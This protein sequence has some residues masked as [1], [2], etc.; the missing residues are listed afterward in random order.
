MN[1]SKLAV[2]PAR[3][4][5]SP[6]R[7]ISVISLVIFAACAATSCA[8]K[9]MDRAELALGTV[10][11]IRIQA[12][13]SDKA[14]DQAFARIKEI[15]RE[16][17]ANT[18]D[19]VIAAINNAAGLSPVAAPEDLRFVISKALNYAA[20]S[21][22]AFDPTIGPIVKLWN[23]GSDGERVP[24][25]AE[26]R[27]TLKL[28]GW[29][30]VV[31]DNAAGTVFLRRPGMR[32]DLGAIAKGYAADEVERTLLENRVRAAVIDLGGNVK[33]T[34]RKT[35]GSKWRVGIQNPFDERGARLG[36]AALDGGYTVVTSGVYERYF[37]GKDGEHYHHIL[38]TGTGYPVK[39]GLV[40]VTIIC[41][42]SVDADGLSTS[43]FALGLE[44]GSALV[45]SLP[46]VEAVF[47][48]AGKRVY[49]TS[50]AP[51]IFKLD[52]ATF[53]AAA[54]PGKPARP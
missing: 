20:I 35:D 2:A 49:M 30:D 9:P 26:I 3:N 39:N 15:D 45:E 46:D 5:Q 13:G 47:V 34:G 32:L 24:E 31:V 38:S 52:D 6:Y 53:I 12:G 27:E 42:A 19:S 33:V 48:D 25:A 23:I 51:A 18:D 21:G 54:I 43:V 14:L 36:I 41:K 44:A 8:G 4:T 17:S 40:S 7:S 1:S 29:R 28:V 37:I 50:G 22:G 16:M 11:S 10:C